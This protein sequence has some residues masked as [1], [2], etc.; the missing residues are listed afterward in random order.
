MH[1]TGDSKMYFPFIN[2]RARTICI[3]TILALFLSLIFAVPGTTLNKQADF[4]FV[5]LGDTRGEI[6]IP[7]GVKQQAEIKSLLKA[8]YKKAPELTFDQD[9]GQ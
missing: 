4:S 1:L 6:F 9:S 8:R 2:S 5:V 7:G 3:S